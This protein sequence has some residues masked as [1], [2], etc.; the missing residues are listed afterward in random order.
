[1]N[2]WALT[3]QLS[4]QPLGKNFG[5]FKTIIFPLKKFYMLFMIEDTNIVGNQEDDKLF[6]ENVKQEEH[7]K[8]GGK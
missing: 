3:D 5:K 8:I 1:M 6:S 4:S 7:C 2:I